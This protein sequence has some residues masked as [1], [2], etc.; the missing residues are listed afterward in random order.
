MELVCEAGVTVEACP[1]SNVHTG[2]ISSVLEH[3]LPRWIDAGVSVCVCTDNTLFSQV[4]QG[5]EMAKIAAIPG[6]SEGKMTRV[7]EAG[8][9]ASFGGPRLAEGVR[10]EA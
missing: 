6:M 1:T 4:Q 8:R 7:V 5:E 10:G 9:R 2:I 3:P